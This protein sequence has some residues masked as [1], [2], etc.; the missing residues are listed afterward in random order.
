[1]RIPRNVIYVFLLIVGFF[2]GI[3]SY[4]YYL[5]QPNNGLFSKT[6]DTT[7]DYV[8]KLGN[9]FG[10]AYFD[11][12]NDHNQFLDAFYKLN[13]EGKLSDSTKTF[14]IFDSHPDLF[15]TNVQTEHIGN[16]VNALIS[17]K[18]KNGNGEIDEIYWIRPNDSMLPISDQNDVGR[19][20]GTSAG[21]VKEFFDLEKDQ[22]F[23]VNNET[24]EIYFTHTSNKNV[25]TVHFHKR[26]LE[27]LPVFPEEK[28]VLMTIDSDYFDFNGFEQ[29][30]NF[31]IHNSTN[32]ELGSKL[33]TFIDKL[34]TANLHPVFVGISR[35]PEYTAGMSR[36]LEVFYRYIGLYSKTGTD[37]M[38]SYSHSKTREGE[39]PNVAMN[40][41]KTREEV[42]N[43]RDHYDLSTIDILYGGFDYEI[44][45]T[46]DN[47][48]YSKAV[49]LFMKNDSISREEAKEK[50]KSLETSKG[51]IF[52]PG[53]RI[54]DSF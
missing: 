47:L 27:E 31:T 3:L 19:D 17:K 51:K 10:N 22:D 9:I 6:H 29:M 34:E 25:R 45:T 36:Y 21:S 18:N 42:E 7:P 43:S 37:Y 24:G 30:H 28:E 39:S 48:E 8:K 54:S 38:A 13:I 41:N 50:L 16:W 23:Y 15:P 1:M 4:R 35:S 40:K 2:L 32:E 33:D 52:L 14:I 5:G 11:L 20:P 49:E 53:N 12:F 46:T 26:Y 44:D